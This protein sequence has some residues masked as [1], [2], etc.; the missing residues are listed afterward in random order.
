MDAS[1]FLAFTACFS[2]LIYMGTLL[3]NVQF[4]GDFGIIIDQAIENDT[5]EDHNSDRKSNLVELFSLP[6]GD[7]TTLFAPSVTGFNARLFNLKVDMKD[8]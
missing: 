2:L 8:V 7:I 6:I 4:Y 5:D 1:F 3:M